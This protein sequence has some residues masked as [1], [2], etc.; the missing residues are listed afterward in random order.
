MVPHAAWSV[1]AE[2]DG[3]FSFKNVRPGVYLV[4]AVPP[5]QAVDLQDPESVRAIAR[6]ATHVTVKPGENSVPMLRVTVS[7]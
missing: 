1:A 5:D 2:V 3:R 6:L 4:A 7:R